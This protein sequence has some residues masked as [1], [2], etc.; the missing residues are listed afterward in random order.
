MP[1]DS[2]LY[3]FSDICDFENIQHP[4]WTS[5]CVELKKQLTA[6]IEVAHSVDQSMNSENME[7]EFKMAY[8]W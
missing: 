4:F 7:S 2:I 3:L 1:L 5:W 6:E 8:M